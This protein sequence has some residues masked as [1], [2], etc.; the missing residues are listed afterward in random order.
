MLHIVLS[1]I[2]VWNNNIFKMQCFLISKEAQ[3][4]DRNNQQ[5]KV[6]FTEMY[7]KIQKKN[8]IEE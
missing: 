7:K 5:I 3:E 1:Y 6:E 8:K 2:Q 4:T